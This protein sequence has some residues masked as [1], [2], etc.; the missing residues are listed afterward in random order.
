MAASSA[1]VGATA[2]TAAAA[3]VNAK[4]H[5]ASD[6]ALAPLSPTHRSVVK[7]IETRA[8]EQR[9]F[10]FHIFEEQARNHGDRLFLIF[11]GKSW[12]YKQF[13]DRIIKA[14]NWLLNDLNVQK[15]EVVAIYGVNT[16][17]YILLWMAL[18]CIGGAPSFLNCNLTGH[19]LL[20][21]VKLC[22]TRYVL[23][24]SESYRNINTCA[25][26]FDDI[27]VTLHLYGPQLIDSLKIMA[28]VPKE[29]QI[30]GSLND[31][32]GLLY[33]SGTTGLPKATRVTVQRELMT[34]YI[35]ARYLK[36]KPGERMFT[37]LPLYHG[38][39]HGL[40]VTPSIHGGS[41]IVL[42]RKFSH[43]TFWP[44]VRESKATILQ[45]VGELCRYL[46]N[47]PPSPLDCQNSVKMAWGNGMRPDVWEPFRQRFGIETINELYAATDSL[48]KS[49]LNANRGEFSRYAVGV[50]G[51]IFKLMAG[52]GVKRI[53]IDMDTQEII[54]DE[55]GRPVVV[56]VNEP[57]EEIYRM[58]TSTPLQEV[59]H[60][61]KEAMEKR[62]LRDAFKRGDVWYR[63]GDLLRQDKDGR[64]YFV[65]RLGDTFRWRSENVS[66]NEVSDIVGTFSQI[67][68]SNVVG[69]EVPKAD[70]RCGLAAVVL[71]PGVTA[72]K[73]DFRGLA[74]HCLT[75]LP[76]YAVPG[77][78]RVTKLIEYTGTF[79]IQ[80]GKIRREGIDPAK[81]TGDDV[82][83]WLPYE[84][85]TYIPFRN[86]DYEA[87]KTGKARI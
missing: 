7:F 20:H 77:F 83:Y 5:I 78:I 66:T 80:K 79:K 42:S 28:P 24:D 73:V 87:L 84:G 26:D 32:R 6:L 16:P 45:Y 39:G 53:K 67:D 71:K 54:K 33:T 49:S 69:V 52:S 62:L 59:Y 75:Q 61:N 37:C 34:G 60:Q 15:D 30:P 85:D 17:E 82:M 9:L 25:K 63:S 48:G 58:D 44:E 35:M 76:R 72:D 51:L 22:G 27:K 74:Q 23:Y 10:T 1:L 8:K 29:R 40:C 43:K 3:Y 14:A 86:E 36:L 47:A 41:T 21:C 38:T 2:L 4:Y 12:T 65:D 31:I 50:R 11:E 13:Y 19:G 81:V 68:E 18:E 57:G 55:A 70:G 56:G 46:V 64:V